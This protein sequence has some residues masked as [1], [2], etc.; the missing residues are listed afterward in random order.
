MAE[1]KIFEFD[2][3]G[4]LDLSHVGG[5]A[6]S[7]WR[8]TRAGFPVPKGF[9]LSVDF[10]APWF[11]RVESSSSWSQL[12]KAN[13]DD[14]K[15]ICDALKEIADQVEFSQ[16]QR[17]E[18]SRAVS[19]FQK[20]SLFAV[21]S[22]SPAEDLDG[23]S[24]AGGYETTLGVTAANI[25]SAILHSFVSL[26][27]ERVARYKLQNGLT[28]DAPRIAIVVQEMVA[29]TASGVAFSLNPQNNCYD[30]A[31]INANFGLGET[32]VGGTVTPDN[33]IVS[34]PDLTIAETKV[35][36]KE[37][38]LWLL[39]TGDTEQRAID[40][41]DKL[42]LSAQQVKDVCRLVTSIEEHFGK[43]MDIEWAYR[44]DHLY[45]LQA[46]PITGY[47]PVFPE[48]LTPIGETKQ[49]YMD[50]IV[51]TQ[52]FSE[53]LSVLG[54]D[55]WATMMSR[56]N[57]P[58]MP[59]GKNGM[60]WDI[61]GRQYLMVSHMKRSGPLMS[62]ALSQYD[63]PTKA[64]F[65]N[66]D[67]AQYVPDKN[68]KELQWFQLRAV[69]HLLSLLNLSVFKGLFLPFQALSDY[70]D[71]DRKVRALFKT[72]LNNSSASF[73][74]ELRIV[75]DS[76]SFLSKTVGVL[77]AGGLA[78]FKLKRM[79]RKLDGA[80]D[81]I[82]TLSMGLPSNPTAKMN[83]MLLKLASMPELQETKSAAAFQE[84]LEKGQYSERFAGAYTEFVE[85]F[86]FRGAKEID[87]ATPRLSETSD[88]LF[89]LMKQ[90]DLEQNAVSK[91]DE[92]R[93]VA[94]DALLAYAKAHGKEHKFLKQEE[95][96]RETM[97][98]REHPKYIFVMAVGMLRKKA[99]SIGM[100]FVEEGRLATKE[101][102]F[103]LTI[104]Q[105]ARAEEDASFDLA[106]VIQSNMQPYKN[107]EQVKHWPKVF[108]S[109]GKI[110]RPMR[111]A[112]DGEL[113]G[114]PI[115]PGTVTGRAKVLFNPYEKTVEPGEI[116][117][118]RSSEPSWAP[119]FVNA[120]GVIMEV[121]GP[122]QHGSIIAREYGL[123]CVSSIENATGL[124]KDG[125]MVEVDGSAGIVRIIDPD[126]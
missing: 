112:K 124:I 88:T 125:D 42:S 73:E 39:E 20:G 95:I 107:V 80:D 52:G 3:T 35:G 15:D 22:S 14:L 29:S 18:L 66:M 100:K 31:V 113:V 23:T 84:K 6:L 59:R 46:R 103:K 74:A 63:E 92:R 50:F 19:G 12:L 58:A 34:K 111:K 69:K 51:M 26:Y 54:M 115:A 101:D 13:M 89:R 85:H 1:K 45:L 61:H 109:R 93:A 121:G 11:E 86:G 116:L 97:G 17:D 118:C 90:M 120:S 21:R 106:Q 43:P 79:F 123:A 75:L 47:F 49:L 60:L 78:K 9:V 96:L 27:D 68:P 98:Y 76:F 64:I 102:V 32:V 70:Q 99:L 8:T 56:A 71:A 87:I 81:L 44:D 105:L 108:D 122:L 16:A 62:A 33:F 104:A 94:F 2:H 40:E 38:A 48:M 25:E 4:N 30:E 37:H 110:H 67:R 53:Q 83:R 41:P 55:V 28:I 57:G 5:K 117:V 114:E 72:E 65:Q 126:E 24:F 10:F 91:V 36:H 119:V 82:Q 7:L 77:T